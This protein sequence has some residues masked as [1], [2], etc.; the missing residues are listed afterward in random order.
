[1]TEGR[2]GAL[3]RAQAGLPATE[4]WGW[5][6]YGITRRGAPATT[7]PQRGDGAR[8]TA[9]WVLAPEGDEGESVQALDCGALAAIVRRVPLAQFS[10]EALR[11]RHDDTAW[12]AEMAHRH[13][14]VIAAIHRQQTILPAK[15]GSVY[16]RAEDV[17]RAVAEA[18]EALLAQLERVE[19]CD[20]WAVHIYAARRA[21]A[22]RVAAEHPTIR[23]LQHELATASPGRAYFLQHKLDE[24]RAAA[25]DQALRE[26][27]QAAY[28]R[29]ARAAAA[30]WPKA[31]RGRSP[32]GGAGRVTPLA[33]STPD[34]HGEIEILRAA[35]LVRRPSAGPFLAEVHSCVEGRDGVRCEYSGPW[36]PYSFAVPTEEEKP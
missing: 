8:R 28:E 13:N 1:M 24:E 30:S 20:E 26:L 33:R 21:V 34:A 5:Y 12:F 15:F 18:Q 23:Q 9:A 35:F 17:R 25:T 29:L 2:E 14:R 11:A 10:E 22:Q 32:R 6:F 31:T 3:P 16:A 4:E 36:S 27:A 19:G 7:Q